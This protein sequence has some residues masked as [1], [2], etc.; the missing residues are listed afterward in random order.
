[1]RPEGLICQRRRRKK[2]E[3][4]KKKTQYLRNFNCFLHKE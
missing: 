3:K 1:M 4:I 2:K